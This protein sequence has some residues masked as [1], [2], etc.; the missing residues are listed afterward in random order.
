MVIGQSHMWNQNWEGRH[1]VCAAI[2]PNPNRSLKPSWLKDSGGKHM[3]WHLGSVNVWELRLEGPVRKENLRRPAGPTRTRELRL[4][5]QTRGR[6]PSCC[7]RS[8]GGCAGMYHI[9][10][11]LRVLP[12]LCSTL[13]VAYVAVARVRGADRESG[14]QA[15]ETPKAGHKPRVAQGV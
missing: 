12:Y 8:R 9:S 5:R 14:C 13:Y 4:Y 15:P 10:Y 3:R 2:R 7:R 11:L 1:I 6:N